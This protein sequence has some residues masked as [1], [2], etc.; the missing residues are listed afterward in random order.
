MASFQAWK[1]SSVGVSSSEARAS[2]RVRPWSCAS[3]NASNHSRTASGR[4]PK[5]RGKQTSALQRQLRERCALG[6]M[7]SLG[8]IEDH[9]KVIS[10]DLPS[11][12]HPNTYQMTELL[13]SLSVIAHLYM[14]NIMKIIVC[15]IAALAC[16]SVGP[17]SVTP[18]DAQV[19]IGVGG[20]GPRLR[21]GPA[22][23]AEY[24]D[25]DRRRDRRFSR[26]RNECRDVSVRTRHRDGSVSVRTTRRCG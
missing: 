15:A 25:E 20:D 21:V 23:R 10:Y 13:R 22:D 14:E 24:R 26:H 9:E 1:A 5:L 17:G 18:A 4:R 2:S 16:L 12:I 3:E 6:S 19:S 7:P 11:E 8:A